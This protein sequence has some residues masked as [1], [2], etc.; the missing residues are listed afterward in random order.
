LVKQ[1]LTFSRQTET[2]KKPINVKLIVVEALKLLRASLP[3]TIE[4]VRELH[5]DGLVLADPTQIHQI[6]MN[7]CTNAGHAMALKG[8]VL[9]VS[10]CK[11]PLEA[12][13]ADVIGVSPGEYIC[14]SVSDTGYGMSPEVVSR[15]F[16]PF[17]TTKKKDQGTGMGLAVVHGIVSS[18]GGG[19]EVN[20]V[21]NQGSTFMV[22]LP[23][24]KTSVIHQRQSAPSLL[25]GNERILFID[26]EPLQ[27]DM[28]NQILTRLGYQVEARSDS[29]ESLNLFASQPNAFDLIITD[30]TMPKLTGVQLASELLK[31]RPDIPIILCSGFSD[32]I[33]KES[34]RLLGIRAYLMK[35]IVMEQL[36]TTIRQ[37]LDVQ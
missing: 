11:S 33:T 9:T 15:I 4:I 19:L 31:I 23:I 7:L 10:L 13:R 21:P 6:V 1:I 18:S 34:A 22:Y 5:S 30:M 8:G 16:D 12:Q 17:Y 3:S 27:V 26:D 29:V 28:I 25:T 37:V 32:A 14:L 2:E 35:P 36:A 24:F 20:S